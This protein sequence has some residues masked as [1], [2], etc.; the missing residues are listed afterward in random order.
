MSNLLKIIKSLKSLQDETVKAEKQVIVA[1]FK[2]LAVF[3]RQEIVIVNFLNH[4]NL[5]LLKI[6]QIMMEYCQSEQVSKYGIAVIRQICCKNDAC[7]DAINKQLNIKHIQM[8]LLTKLLLMY[9][10]SEIQEM[11]LVCVMQLQ[12]R[13]Q[14]L[15]TCKF[16]LEKIYELMN[17]QVAKSI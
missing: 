14:A 9:D 16:S 13:G 15:V 11:S 5:Y 12:S 3:L 8:F 1:V 10:D 7:Y 6:M 4:N 17:L 2:C